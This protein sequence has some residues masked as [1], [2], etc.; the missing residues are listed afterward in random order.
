MNRDETLDPAAHLPPAIRRRAAEWLALR[1]ARGFT[2]A[3]HA[4]FADWLAADARH[5]SAF[6]EIAAG[7]SRFD[8]LAQYPH[9]ADAAPDPDLLAPRRDRSRAGWLVPLA[10][11]AAIALGAFAGWSRWSQAPLA[12]AAA[13]LAASPNLQRLPDGSLVELN[14]GAE[15][16]PA[17]TPQE[18][19]VRLV[20]GE[21]HFTVAPDREHPFVVEAGGVTLRALGTA[22]NVRLDPAE[23]VVLVTH[24]LVKVTPPPEANAGAAAAEEIPVL[25]ARDRVAVPRHAAPATAPIAVE[26]LAMADVDRALAWQSRHITLEQVPL[27]DVLAQFRRSAHAMPRVTIEGEALKQLRISGRVRTDDLEGLIEVLET[28]FGVAAERH[29]AEEIVL[30]MR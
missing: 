12:P 29:G 8:A 16:T 28:S 9:S 15:V 10:A 23:V 6:A 19:R 5:R 7:W 17:F 1:E 2:T 13:T 24:G 14:A 4:E 11:A 26:K 22:F 18:R 21:A 30:R 25:T 20:R 3:E 27:S